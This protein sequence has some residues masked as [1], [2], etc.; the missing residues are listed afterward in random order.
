MALCS[1]K[2]CVVCGR[3][4]SGNECPSCKNKKEK[5]ELEEFLRKLKEGRNQQ[6]MIDELAKMVFDLQRK[7]PEYVPPPVY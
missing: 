2:T 6:E 1:Q 7:K 4:Y 5:Q 3:S